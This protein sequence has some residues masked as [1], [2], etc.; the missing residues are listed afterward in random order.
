MG[1][2]TLFEID[3]EVLRE[4]G[5]NLY[6]DFVRFRNENNIPD[7]DGPVVAMESRVFSVK[8]KL[9]MATTREDLDRARSEFDFARTC[10]QAVKGAD[11]SETA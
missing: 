1:Q 4:V 2:D 3:L 6:A 5:A 8:E 11:R 7:D 9:L 10:L